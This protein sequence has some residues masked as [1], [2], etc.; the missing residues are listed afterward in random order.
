MCSIY[1][2]DTNHNIVRLR[3]LKWLVMGDIGAYNKEFYQL[4][5]K[6]RI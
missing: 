3:P 4:V 1:I 6:Q 5:K 2:D